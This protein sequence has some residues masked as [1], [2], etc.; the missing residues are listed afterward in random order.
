MPTAIEYA[1]RIR[2]AALVGTPTNPKGVPIALADLIVAQSKHETGNYTS[3]FFLQDNNAFGYSY[4]SG[5][6]W[7]I[8]RGGI[9]D[10]GAPIA[11][12]ASIEDSTSEM[13]DWIYRRVAEGKFPVNLSDITTPER[14]A[15]LLKNAGYYEDKEITYREGIK[16]WF[17]SN[18]ETAVAGLL[19]LGLTLSA[20][21]FRKE[22]K[23]LLSK[24]R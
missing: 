9:A 12:Y 1:A 7:Q 24:K 13:I 19:V 20:W 17:Q 8:G 21:F 15:E 11:K 16:R 4:V 6:R 2:S 14:Y 10:N 3:N 23:K 5:A 22:L 18:P